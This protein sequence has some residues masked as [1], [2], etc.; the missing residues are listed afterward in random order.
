MKSFVSL[1]YHE[2]FKTGTR[3]PELS[4]SVTSYFVSQD[5]FEQHIAELARQGTWLDSAQMRSF[6]DAKDTSSNMVEQNRPWVQ[7][8]FDDGWRGSVDNAGPVLERHGCEALLFVTTDLISRPDFVNPH[9]LQRLPE[10]TYRIGSHGRT[11]RLL[12]HL[13]EKEIRE[14]LR[15]SKHLLEDIVGYEIDMLS[16]PGG[17]ADRRVCTIAT[18]LGYRFVFTS[19]IHANPSR[20]GSLDIGRVAIKRRTSTN[21]VKRY[22]NQNFRTERVRQNVVRF[23]RR[24]LSESIYGKLRRCLLRERPNQNDMTDLSEGNCAVSS[25]CPSRSLCGACE[26][27]GEGDPE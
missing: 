4:P 7:I 11:H 26:V 15:S 19:N 27:I 22:L 10:K 14:E 17:A 12:A 20:N 25:T 16:I 1:M 18:E 8:T 9:D 24:L 3:F 6:F 23:G 13:R 21:S 2:V 5:R